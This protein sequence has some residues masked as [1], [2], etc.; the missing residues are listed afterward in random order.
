[1]RETLHKAITWMPGGVC[2]LVTGAA[3]LGGEAVRVKIWDAILAALNDPTSIAVIVAVVVMLCVSWY[4]TRPSK[5]IREGD[6]YT[7]NH[8]GSGD[9]EMHF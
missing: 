2:A 6:V 5:Q 1:M 3:A 9:N 4:A 8:A 7:Q